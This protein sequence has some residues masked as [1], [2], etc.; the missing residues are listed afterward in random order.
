MKHVVIGTAGHVD[1]GKTALIRAL[2]GR[3]TDRLKEEQEREISIELGF[4]WLD[5]KDGTRCGVID[6]PGHEKFIGHMLSGVPGMDLV[7]VVVAADEGIMPQ[8]REHLDIL[9]LLGVRKTILVLN[10]C[11]LVSEEWL[12][13]AEEVI[14]QQ[15]KETI[16]QDAPCVRV[17][18]LTGKGIEELKECIFSMVKNEVPERDCGG[19]ARLP[20]DR[21]FTVPGHGTVVTGTLISGTV[22]KEDRME[23]FPEGRPCRVRNIQVHGKNRES[24]F[25]G[26][27]SALNLTG[28][29][30]EEIRRG[31]VI[32]PPGSLAPSCRL[33]VRLRI[34]KDSRRS[35][36]NRSRLHLYLGTDEILCRAVLLDCDELEPGET[37]FAQLQLEEPAAVK[38]GDRFVVRFYSPLQTIGGGMVL[39]PDAQRHRRFD[40]STLRNLKLR[41]TGAPA[42]LLSVRIREAGNRLIA[43][44]ELSGMFSFSGEELDEGLLQLQRDRVIHEIRLSGNTWYWH[45]DCMRET[46]Q[47][48]SRELAVWHERHPYRQGMDRAQVHSAFLK[49]LRIPLFDACLELLAEEKLLG[50][51]QDSISLYGFEIRKDERFLQIEKSIL[52]AFGEKG[53]GMLSPGSPGCK[54]L[55]EENAGKEAGRGAAAKDDTLRDVLN[56]LVRENK[57]VRCSEDLYFLQS[58][59]REA[60]QRIRLYFEKNEVLKFTQVKEMFGISRKE[61]RT[62]MGYF[63]NIQVTR[64]TGAETERTSF[65]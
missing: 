8:T 2:T 46:G 34:L 11:D 29:R 44:K 41:E 58:F 57:I 65:R 42:D 23:I 3:N 53:N 59:I 50:C 63:D 39:N 64:K 16:L 38:R 47:K 28:I 19:T 21:V 37:G 25:A 36:K 7:L 4:T 30:K 61:T 52:D 10:K 13:M 6:V 45:D 26:Q 18:A 5:L 20:V 24:C 51:T 55:Q 9:S 56:V 49:N 22:G 12:E 54:G 60:E 17:S 31:C 15:L 1:H 32:A 48:I 35:L 14:R 62:L 33:D 27:R 40:E 43:K